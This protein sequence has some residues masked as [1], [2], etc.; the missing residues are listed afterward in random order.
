MSVRCG[1]RV[2]HLARVVEDVQAEDDAMGL[3]AADDGDLRPVE[4]V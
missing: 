2:L 4:R 1:L 3:R